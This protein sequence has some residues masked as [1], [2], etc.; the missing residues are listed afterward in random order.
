MLIFRP[1]VTS[2]FRRKV[3]QPTKMQI[4]FV[5]VFYC[6]NGERFKSVIIVIIT[7]TQNVT[8]IDRLGDFLI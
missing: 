1:F 7:V 5:A 6:K 3:I 8:F 4:T 2:Y